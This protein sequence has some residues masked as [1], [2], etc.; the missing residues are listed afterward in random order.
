MTDGSTFLLS[1][2]DASMLK[3]AFLPARFPS[4]MHKIGY[5]RETLLKL[6][7]K[8]Y[9]AKAFSPILPQLST[10][11]KEGYRAGSLIVMGKRHMLQ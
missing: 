8:E 10:I 1:A 9:A 6:L 3:E 2:L 4:L 7:K 5:W 11:H